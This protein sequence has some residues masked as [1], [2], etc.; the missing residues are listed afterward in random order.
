MSPLPPRLRNIY[1]FALAGRPPNTGHNLH[2]DL[3]RCVAPTTAP[4][5]STNPW[6]VHALVVPLLSRPHCVT[7]EPAF[8][9]PDRTP[10]SR[11][12]VDQRDPV[13]RDT[14]PGSAGQAGELRRPEENALACRVPGPG[15][16]RWPTLP[17]EPDRGMEDP[18]AAPPGSTLEQTRPVDPEA[19]RGGAATP[20][21]HAPP[22]AASPPGM[23]PTVLHPHVGTT[24]GL[25]C[26]R[27]IRS[28][29]VSFNPLF[30]GAAPVIE[31]LL[32]CP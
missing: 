13:G 2:A 7:V 32:A 4:R 8:R 24:P 31:P 3:R 17:S 5:S 16:P 11:D 6:Q 1:R 30:C 28:A 15:H 25:S 20:S 12:I 9:R 18:G 21:S 10:N 26:E 27:P 22:R 29:L 19:T 14:A 23:A